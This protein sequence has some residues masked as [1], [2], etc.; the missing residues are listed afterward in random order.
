[1]TRSRSIQVWFAAVA[2]I[3]AAGVVLGASVTVGTAAVLM[4]LC[5]APPAII[6]MLWPGAQSAT[7]ADVIHGADRRG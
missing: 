4:A 3:V 7:V 6:L 5:L 1:V 2:L